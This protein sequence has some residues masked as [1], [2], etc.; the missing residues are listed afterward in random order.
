MSRPEHQN[1]PELFYDENEARKYN[2]CSR[3]VEIQTEIANRALELLSLPEGKRALL[4]DIGCGSGLSGEAIEEAGHVWIGCDIS[5]DML[6]IASERESD[7]GDALQHD[8]GLGLPFRPAT[9]DG[10]ISVSALQWLCYSDKQGQTA[11]VRLARFFSSLY[12]CMKRGAK[13]AL[14]FYPESPEQAVLIAQAASKVGFTGGLVVDYPNSSKAKKF[15][16]CLGFEHSY[17]APLPL[18]TFEGNRDGVQV[19]GRS[20]QQ[21]TSRKGKRTAPKSK[22]WVIAKKEKQRQQGKKV[23][24]DTK[25]TARRRGDR[26]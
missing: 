19:T 23:R 2:S 14:Q 3:I 7:V 10:V 12:T 13:A 11:Q 22:D 4:L 21:H 17:S 8:M 18:G 20:R 15:Y 16:L 26:F 6:E 9:F 1:A 25:F 5:R 24:A